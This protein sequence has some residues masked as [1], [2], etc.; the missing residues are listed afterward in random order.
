MKKINSKQTGQGLLSPLQSA[1]TA[2]MVCMWVAITA[3]SWFAGLHIYAV[4]LIMVVLGFGIGI[5]FFK[6]ILDKTEFD[7]TVTRYTFMNRVRNGDSK[8]AMFVLPLKKLK[9]HIPIEHVHDD[10]LIE[11]TRKRYGVLFRYDPPSTSKSELDGFHRQ[12]EYV[13]NSFPSEVEVSFHFYDMID[14]TN[15]LADT[16]LQAINTEGKTL[17]QKKHLHGMYVEA[18]QDDAPRV[19]TAYL[20][21]VKLGTYKSNEHAMIAYN[22]IVPGLLKALRERGIY[23]TQVI[24]EN[25]VAIELKQFAVM[26]KYL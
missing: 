21:S 2:L 5:V 16:L 10:G 13:A 9:K 12:M 25:N 7:R 22:S 19:S 20:L 24:G 4:V 11:Y 1:V 18:T 14:R 17:A 23:T 26:E 3:I 15:L 6:R 8:I